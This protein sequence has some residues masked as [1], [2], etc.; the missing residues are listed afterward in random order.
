MCMNKQKYIPYKYS[1]D[2]KKYFEF[3]HNRLKK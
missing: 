1:T 2:N 3:V